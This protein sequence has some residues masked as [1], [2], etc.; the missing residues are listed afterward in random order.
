M[1]DWADAAVEHIHKKLEGERLK[2]EAMLERGRIRRVQAPLL[3]AAVKAQA[4]DNCRQFNLKA[5]EGRLHLEETPDARIEITFQ[6]E[7]ILRTLRVNF[8]KAA[9]QLSWGCEG[10]FGGWSVEVDNG[11][12]ARFADQ[13]GSATPE[14]IVF[15]MM[16]ALVMGR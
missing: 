8:D 5:E 11:G 12:D 13:F 14:T 6:L 4:R 15:R 9:A 1:N 10:A 2:Q 16:N 3:W 7:G